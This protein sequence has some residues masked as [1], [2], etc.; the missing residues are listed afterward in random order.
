[1]SYLSTELNSESLEI[2]S[3]QNVS[4]IC[5]LLHT[6]SNNLNKCKIHSIRLFSLKQEN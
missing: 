3:V 5:Q 1:M 6:F 2:W 4:V